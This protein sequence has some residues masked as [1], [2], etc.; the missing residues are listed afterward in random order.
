MLLPVFAHIMP[1]HYPEIVLRKLSVHLCWRKDYLCLIQLD[2]L[3]N[4][5]Y[6][7]A[8]NTVCIN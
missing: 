8:G 6:L 7:M 3:Y 1:H 5:E 2:F 4:I